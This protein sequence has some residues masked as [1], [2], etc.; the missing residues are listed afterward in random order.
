VEG[1]RAAVADDDVVCLGVVF[2]TRS[3]ARYI[4]SEWYAWFLYSRVWHE[5]GLVRAF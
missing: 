2:A 5:A 1:G 3:G 4:A